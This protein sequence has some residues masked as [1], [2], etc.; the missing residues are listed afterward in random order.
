MLALWQVHD[1]LQE[2]EGLKREVDALRACVTDTAQ[3]AQA[4]Q[5]RVQLAYAIT[6]AV[7][8]VS[9]E[10]PATLL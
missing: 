4:W 1:V 2:N 6:T 5:C 3:Q 9:P 8:Q 10:W 7:C